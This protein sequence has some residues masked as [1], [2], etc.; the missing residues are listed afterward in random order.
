MNLSLSSIDFW[1]IAEGTEEALPSDG[2]EKDKDYQKRVREAI[3]II[4]FNLVDV[5]LAHIKN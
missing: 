2:R 3:F 4:D 1:E 5:Q